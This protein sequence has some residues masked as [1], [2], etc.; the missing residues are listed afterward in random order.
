MTIPLPRTW[1]VRVD[2]LIS[3]FERVSLE[4]QISIRR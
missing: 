2:I 3:D 1:R 4:E